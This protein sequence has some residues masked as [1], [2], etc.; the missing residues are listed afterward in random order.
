MFPVNNPV[1]FNPPKENKYIKTK[2]NIFFSFKN[3]LCEKNIFKKKI[4]KIMIPQIIIEL[5]SVIFE[6]NEKKFK[7]IGG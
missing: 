6:N 7:V 5:I 4:G 3:N 2:I 1:K